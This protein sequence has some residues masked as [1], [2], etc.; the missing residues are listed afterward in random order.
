VR[1]RPRESA[2]GQ[3]QRDRFQRKISCIRWR[4]FGGLSSP[5]RAARSSTG[6]ARTET[7]FTADELLREDHA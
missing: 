7:N 1:G 4:L 6:T 2:L 3:A 5:P